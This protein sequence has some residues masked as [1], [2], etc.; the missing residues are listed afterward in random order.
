MAADVLLH[1]CLNIEYIRIIVIMRTLKTLGK[2]ED[3]CG[4][5]VSRSRY[6]HAA[7]RG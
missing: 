3:Q 2:L 6:T 4:L 5:G 7:H 1:S